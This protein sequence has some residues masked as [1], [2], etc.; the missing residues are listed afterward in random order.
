MRRQSLIAA[1]LTMA[2]VFTG[3]PSTTDPEPQPEPPKTWTGTEQR[4]ESWGNGAPELLVN[5]PGAYQLTKQ[6]GPDFDVYSVREADPADASSLAAAV[7]YIGHHPQANETAGVTE[8]GM[9]GDRKVDWVAWQEGSEGNA[10]HHRELH[11]RD[12]FKGSQAKDVKQ[13]VVH[14]MV[15]GNN[16]QAVKALCKAM[17]SLRIA[18]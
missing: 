6:D 3:C 5:L 4:L 17:A 8:S 12:F 2:C 18:G 14:I 16:E 13:L 1:A 11:L 9:I 10:M 7:I 15:A